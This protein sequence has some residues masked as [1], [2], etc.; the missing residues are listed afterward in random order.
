MAD[1]QWD[2]AVEALK[3]FNKEDV[4]CW[5]EARKTMPDVLG[6]KY[7][8]QIELLCKRLGPLYPQTDGF[9]KYTSRAYAV[10]RKW[11]KENEQSN[12]KE[13]N[14]HIFLAAVLFLGGRP[15]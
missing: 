7:P 11:L 1:K 8:I 10:K 2:N 3:V 4:A 13:P 6:K 12:S 9:G 5:Q 15:H 14:L